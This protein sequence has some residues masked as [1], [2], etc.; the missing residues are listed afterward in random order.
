MLVGNT[1]AE[2]AVVKEDDVFFPSRV[3]NL[4]TNLVLPLSLDVEVRAESGGRPAG[5]HALWLSAPHLPARASGPIEVCVPNA[6]G[7]ADHAV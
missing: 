1:N 5:C 7:P 4:S 3:T 2:R 6:L